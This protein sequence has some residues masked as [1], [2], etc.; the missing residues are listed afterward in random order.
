[1]EIKKA[2][3]IIEENANWDNHNCTQIVMCVE[4]LLKSDFLTGDIPTVH[5]L[6]NEY[7]EWV[8]ICGESFDPFEGMDDSCVEDDGEE[9]SPERCWDESDALWEK[10]L[11]I[12]EKEYEKEYE[13]E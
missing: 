6:R 12:L 7:H 8:E 2:L 9:F 10:L 13:E 11:P 5:F 3:K 1:M 4:R